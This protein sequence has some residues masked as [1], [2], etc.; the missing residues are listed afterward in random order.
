MLAGAPDPRI[1][2]IAAEWSSLRSAVRAAG[3]SAVIPIDR[4]DPL[5]TA[6]AALSAARKAVA[7]LR[8]DL[9]KIL[10]ERSPTIYEHIARRLERGG[11]PD[12]FS[13]HALQMLIMKCQRVVAKGTT[14]EMT[15][16]QTGWGGNG[17]IWTPDDHHPDARG[18]KGRERSGGPR[19]R[20][21]HGR[22]DP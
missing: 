6:A 16:I 5:A 8:G 13:R 14:E 9:P 7:L 3:R 12:T 18:R 11:I 2:P 1:D 22:G 17:P 4:N 19:A 20:A 21:R 15:L 10:G